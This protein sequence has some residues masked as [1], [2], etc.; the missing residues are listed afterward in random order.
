MKHKALAAPKVEKDFICRSNDLY[1][2]D[3]FQ[4]VV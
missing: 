2:E 1:V 4:K 3:Y